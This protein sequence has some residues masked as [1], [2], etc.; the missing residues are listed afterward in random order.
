MV[1]MLGKSRDTTMDYIAVFCDR[2]KLSENHSVIAPVAAMCMRGA[3]VKS[4]DTGP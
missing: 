4:V 2:P 3:W 1:H